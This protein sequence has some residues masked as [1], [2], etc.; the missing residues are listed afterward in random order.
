MPKQK[1]DKKAKIRKNGQYLKPEG[2]SDDETESF[3]VNNVD[4]IRKNQGNVSR[5]Q[6]V[7]TVNMLLYSLSILFFPSNSDNTVFTRT[8]RISC[9]L[10]RAVWRRSI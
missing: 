6:K 9:R 7:K 1:P 8:D 2:F 10:G 3:E 5:K 4:G